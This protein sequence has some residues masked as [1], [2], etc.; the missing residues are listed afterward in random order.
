MFAASLANGTEVQLKVHAA[1]EQEIDVAMLH[2]L[3]G[4]RLSMRVKV[5]SVRP[6][7]KTESD[8]GK[9]MNTPPP[10]PKK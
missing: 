4:K 7:T 6:A 2:P 5:V 9:V 3:A 10:L 1:R 8:Q